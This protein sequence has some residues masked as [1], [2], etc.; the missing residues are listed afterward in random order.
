MLRCI[1]FMDHEMKVRML[2]VL[3]DVSLLEADYT[4]D[5]LNQDNLKYFYGTLTANDHNVMS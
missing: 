1:N 4:E 5:Y 2:Y 3:D